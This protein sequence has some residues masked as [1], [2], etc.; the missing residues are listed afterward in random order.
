VNGALISE[1]DAIPDSW[2]PFIAAACNAQ[3]EEFCRAFGLAFVPISAYARGTVIDPTTT[4]ILRILDDIAVPG[5]LGFHDFAGNAAF[6][7][8]E[9]QDVGATA[10]TTSHE[11]LELLGDVKCDQWSPWS[12]GARQAHEVADRVEGDSYVETVSVLGETRGVPVSNYLL[13]PAF[14]AGSPGPWDRMGRLTSWDGMTT[15][16]YVIVA[17]A[18]G[19]VSNVFADGRVAPVSFA[20]KLRNGKSRTLRRLRTPPPPVGLEGTAA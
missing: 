1:S 11:W 3:G 10:I 5:A 17:D 16:G 19:N 7:E 20:R 13:P 4:H 6:A 8:I 14:V 12:D 15:G 9:A 2:L 18:Q